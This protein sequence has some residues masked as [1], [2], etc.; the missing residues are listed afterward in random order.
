[1]AS[2]TMAERFD[3]LY[4]EEIENIISEATPKSMKRANALGCFDFQ[5]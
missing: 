5:M 4:A 1:M 2:P 3:N